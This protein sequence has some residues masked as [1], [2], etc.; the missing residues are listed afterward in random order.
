MQRGGPLLVVTLGVACAATAHAYPQY[1]AKSY[2]N[3]GTCHYSPTGGGLLNAY[4]H[5]TLE[6][7][8]PDVLEVGAIASLREALAK[9]A[10]TGFTDEGAA[11]LHWD[12]GL[13]TRLLTVSAPTEIGG[14]DELFVV[15]MLAEVGGVLA[16]DK[17]LAY[18]TVTPRRAGADAGD[19]TVF[20]REHWGQVSLAED[21]SLRAG[22]LVLPFGLRIPD[23]TQY[24]REDLGFGKWDQSYAI[25]LDTFT[26]NWMWAS[27]LFAGDL[28]NTPRRLQERG[29]VVS[30]ARNVPGTASFGASLL[31]GGAK[32]HDRVAASLFARLRLLERTYVMGEAAG[33]H[34]RPDAG[35]PGQTVY[36]GFVRAGWFALES[37]DLFVEVGGRAI[38]EAF[39]LTKLRY[40]GGANWQLLPWVELAPSLLMEEDPETGLKSTFVGQLHV[41]Y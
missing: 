9:N 23:H 20:S 8:I 28:G 16:Y 36:A 6:A 17:V 12:V 24:T 4:G 11:A 15:P 27:A 1:I 21:M 33:A 14:E 32:L 37:L 19:R 41:I 3:C 25:E 26:E 40:M 2:T 35:G 30:L 31:A 5:A 18:G 7:T 29:A 39:E 13:D 34:R 10:V 22:R 38:P